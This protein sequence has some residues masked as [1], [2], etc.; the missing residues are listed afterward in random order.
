MRGSMPD[1]IYNV[2]TKATRLIAPFGLDA[3]GPAFW[4][5]GLAVIVGEL[6]AMG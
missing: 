6:D 5:I 4:G 3:R 2:N 1:C